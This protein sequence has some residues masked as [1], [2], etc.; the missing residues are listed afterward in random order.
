MNADIMRQYWF[1]MQ[2]FRY[3]YF[4]KFILMI[5]VVILKKKKN[6]SKGWVKCRITYYGKFKFLDEIASMQNAATLR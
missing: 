2:R 6:R 3:E 5:G 1:K 4:R